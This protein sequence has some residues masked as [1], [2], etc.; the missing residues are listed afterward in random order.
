[1]RAHAGHGVRSRGAVSL[2]LAA[3]LAAGS[4]A[5][6]VPTAQGDSGVEVAAKKKKCKKGFV[7]KKG[8]CK[9]RSPVATIPPGT[10]TPGGT[11]ALTGG[12][13]SLSI[14]PTSHD[15]GSHPPETHSA[16]QSFVVTNT[17]PNPASPITLRTDGEHAED[18]LVGNDLCGGT[19][20]TPGGT[21]TLDVT[22]APGPG[23]LGPR[24]GSLVIYG[25]PAASVSAT[26]SAFGGPPIP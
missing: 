18:F 5:V 14:T 3:I 15:F 20:L 9:R 1:M 26:L 19:T 13:T 11:T 8:R 7:R 2:L 6:V 12:P 10:T 23:S 21:C 24:E 22:F 17:G 4:V 25:P 16:P